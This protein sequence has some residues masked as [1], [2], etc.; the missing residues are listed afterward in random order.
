[1]E[2]NA[3]GFGGANKIIDTKHNSSRADN[4]PIADMANNIEKGAKV[5]EFD[6][7]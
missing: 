7:F 3:G 4:T 2:H 1:M 6:L 5:Y